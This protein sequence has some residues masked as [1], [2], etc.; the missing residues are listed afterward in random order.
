MT[1]TEVNDFVVTFVVKLRGMKTKNRLKNKQLPLNK[2]E[3]T[4]DEILN[5]TNY[6]RIVA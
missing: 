6:K 5:D 4:F 3:N 2:N 1:E